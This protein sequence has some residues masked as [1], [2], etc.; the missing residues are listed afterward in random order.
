MADEPV[1]MVCRDCGGEDVTRE[2]WAV[3][4]VGAQEWVLGAVFDH[5]F[6][7]RCMIAAQLEEAPC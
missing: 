4:D 7:H 2:A 1:R 5:A 3:W 6:C